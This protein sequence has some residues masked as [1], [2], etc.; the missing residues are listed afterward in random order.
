MTMILTILGLALF[1]IIN[2]IDNAVINAEVLGKMGRPARRWFLLWGIIIAVFLVRGLLPWLILWLATP[3]LSAWQALTATLFGSD[4]IRQSIETAAPPLL[5]GAGI[6]LIFLFLHWLFLEN[7]KFGLVGERFI[8]SHGLWFFTTASFI[9]T[10]IVWVAIKINPTMALGAVIG[11]SAFFLVHGFKENAERMEQVIIKGN[12][13]ISDWSK[14]FY[15]EAIDAC[16]SI[17]GVLGAFAFTLSI[18]L[19]LVGNGIGAF[20]V[21]RL[22]VGNID[23]VKRLVYLKNGAMYSILCLGVIMILEAFGE[24]FPAWIS[25]LITFIIIGYF[26]GKSM[27]EIRRAL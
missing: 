9:L 26:V 4:F 21:R 10:G 13:H 7:K 5:I 6:F 22:T 12:E 24:H 8:F 15:L 14:I 1:E 23:R 18:P 27:G 11:S 19:I 25:P 3:Q 17:D 20:V 16:F 2:S